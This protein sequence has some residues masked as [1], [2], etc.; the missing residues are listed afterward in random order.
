MTTI[1]TTEQAV[2]AAT[3]EF[4]DKIKDALG[5]EVKIEISVSNARQ[6]LNRSATYCLFDDNISRVQVYDE[7]YLPFP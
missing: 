2:I 7:S 5:A 3:R 1:D 4:E 6:Q